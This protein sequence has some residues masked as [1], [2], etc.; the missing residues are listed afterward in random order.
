MAPSTKLIGKMP[1]TKIWTSNQ[2][3]ESEKLRFLTAEMITQLLKKSSVHFVVA[4]IGKK[5]EWIPLNDCFDFWKTEVKNRIG[6]PVDGSSLE[7]FPGSYFYFAS[8]WSAT[9]G[10]PIV[11]LEIYH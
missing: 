7:D 4:C 1:L 8:E 11:L 3:L 2:E 10:H 5:L 9:D 6:D